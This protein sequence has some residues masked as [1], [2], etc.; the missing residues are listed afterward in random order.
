MSHNLNQRKNVNVKCFHPVIHTTLNN[1][2][3][4]KLLAQSGA[5][6]N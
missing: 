1:L 5:F 6:L 4:D 2:V 3:S